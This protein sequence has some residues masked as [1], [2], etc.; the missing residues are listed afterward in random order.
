MFD[1]NRPEWP[2]GVFAVASKVFE[3]LLSENKN[4]YQFQQLDK[5]AV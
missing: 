5:T 2:P 4:Q 1:I 3:K